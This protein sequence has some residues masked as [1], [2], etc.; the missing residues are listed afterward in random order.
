MNG[1]TLDL[2]R[3]DN[4][5]TRPT[6]DRRKRMRSSP[7][8]RVASRVCARLEVAIGTRGHACITK[9]VNISESGILVEGYQGQELE[10][11]EKVRVLIRGVVSD[12]DRR[13]E[14][15]TMY[16]AR[17]EDGHLALTFDKDLIA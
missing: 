2:I 17:A 6:P 7:D 9:S 4:S 15:M 11:G 3:L 10:V 16:V 14:F 5:E 8:R 1:A 12:K 13:D